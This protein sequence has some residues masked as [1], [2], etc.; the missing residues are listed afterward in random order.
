MNSQVLIGPDVY[1]N[2][3]GVI[4]RSREKPYLVQCDIKGMYHQVLLSPADRD[5][6]RFVYFKNGDLSDK[7]EDGCFNVHVFGCASSRYCATVALR[8]CAI[9]NYTQ[10]R[11][12]VQQIVN[13]NF[14][15]DDGCIPLC[16]IEHGKSLLAE[17]RCLLSDSGFVLNKF[18]S[19]EPALLSEI[20]EKYK[21]SFSDYHTLIVKTLG[22]PWH[23]QS[24]RFVVRNS[25]QNRPANKRG[26]LSV[27]ASIYDPLGIISIFL[28]P[29]KLLLQQLTIRKLAWDQV[30][31]ASE[32]E[33]WTQLCAELHLLNELSLHRC[34]QPFTC[35]DRIEIHCFVDASCLAYGCC[36]YLRVCSNSKCKVSLSFAKSRVSPIKPLSTPK[37]EI[38]A[39][40]CGM[41]VTAFVKQEMNLKISSE[42]YYTAKAVINYLHNTDK[43]FNIFVGCRVAAI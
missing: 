5:R 13:D 7:I 3:V 23:V 42:F 29:A 11:S 9:D 41:R 10:A 12:K 14:F 1:N 26:I 22:I 40:Y 24:D 21:L 28:L 35:P 20:S 43:H 2:Q 17:L 39:A 38:A 30:I 34:V 4:L 27:I 19:N 8:K 32:F 6:F 16:N 18:I 33:S 36:I 37:L 31:E 15:V 25:V